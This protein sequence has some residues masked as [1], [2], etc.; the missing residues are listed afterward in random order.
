MRS[1]RGRPRQ[2]YMGEIK[3]ERRYMM[4]KKLKG[5]SCKPTNPG[6]RRRRMSRRRESLKRDFAEISVNREQNHFYF[7]YENIICISKIY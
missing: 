1:E 7:P 5:R 2:E 6:S 3:R 4:I